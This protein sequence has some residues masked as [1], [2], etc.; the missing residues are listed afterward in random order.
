MLS[1]EACLTW[2]LP[3]PFAP[4]G[5][6]E[7]CRRCCAWLGV[8]LVTLGRCQGFL[9]RNRLVTRDAPARHAGSSPP[10][11]PRRARAWRQLGWWAPGLGKMPP[12]AGSPLLWAWL[13]HALYCS[14]PA[15]SSPGP[16]SPAGRCSPSEYLSTQ[17]QRCS[18]CGKHEVKSP[19]GELV[20]GCRCKGLSST[21][22]PSTME[23]GARVHDGEGCKLGLY[24]QVS[25]MRA[26]SPATLAWCLHVCSCTPETLQTYGASSSHAPSEVRLSI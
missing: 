4:A 5:P 11:A 18:P 15:R 16:S 8:F 25:H 9:L 12:S 7:G 21:Q 3:A 17:T 2:Q 19:E 14:G 24:A 6:E 13:L 23:K 10:F 1:P 20:P 26:P 22:H